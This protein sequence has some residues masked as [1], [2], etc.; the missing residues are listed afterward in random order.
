MSEKKY[1]VHPGKNL[2]P[3]GAVNLPMGYTAL[4]LAYKVKES[5]AVIWQEGMNWD[6]YIHLHPDPSH[7]W[8]C[9]TKNGGKPPKQPKKGGDIKLKKDGKEL[10]AKPAPDVSVPPK[11]ESPS[12]DPPAPPAEEKPSEPAPEKPKGKGGKKSGRRGS[13][14]NK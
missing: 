14:K 13:K 1:A 8:E 3:N 2:S 12:E 6:A 5:E 11:D 4:C 7:K 9:P 10:E